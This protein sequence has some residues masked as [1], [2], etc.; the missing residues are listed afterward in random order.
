MPHQK[1]NTYSISKPRRTQQDSTLWC[2]LC[3]TVL[4]P[5]L[6]QDTELCSKTT[7]Y[8]TFKLMTQQCSEGVGRLVGQRRSNFDPNWGMVLVW[9]LILLNGTWALNCPTQCSSIPPG[10][11]TFINL[12]FGY[13]LSQN[14]WD[15]GIN[16]GHLRSFEILTTGQDWF[17]WHST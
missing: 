9:S 7:L 13:I 1:P 14:S 8:V 17:L 2:I 15:Q 6:L 3:N 4:S 16:S 11:F 10:P 5:A 12:L